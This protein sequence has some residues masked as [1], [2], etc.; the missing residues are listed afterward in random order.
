MDYDILGSHKIS[1]IS[2][3]RSNKLSITL[4]SVK[5]Q[6]RGSLE[7]M[8]YEKKEVSG[9]HDEYIKIFLK[10]KSD[11]KY[12]IA[13]FTNQGYCDFLLNT[14]LIL[15]TREFISNGDLE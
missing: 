4:H 9:F 14:D 2:A 6:K 3:Q 11:N 7:I 10:K 1:I 5:L 15:S 8:Q 13:L 12:V